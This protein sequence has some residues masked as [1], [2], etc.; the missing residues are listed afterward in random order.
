[1]ISPVIG[2]LHVSADEP[3]DPTILDDKSKQAI[4][5]LHREVNGR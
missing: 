2:Q 5:A 1:M 3:L 4:A